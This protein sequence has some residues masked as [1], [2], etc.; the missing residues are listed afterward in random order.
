MNNVQQE[1]LD[2]AYENY[3]KGG[4]IKWLKQ[5]KVETPS[6]T[7]LATIPY[8]KEEFIEK[9][10]TDDEF[11]KEWG[12]KI[13]EIKLSQSQRFNWYGNKIG[14]FMHHDHI[15]QEMDEYGVPTKQIIITQKD[16]IIQIYE[17]NTREIYWITI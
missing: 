6:G 3:L 12:L 4:N 2:K 16:T 9:C 17:Q 5:I 11:S 13:E 10:K 15:E 14:S 7:I 8:D 1:L